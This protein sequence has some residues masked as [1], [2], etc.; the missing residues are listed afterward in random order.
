MSFFFRNIEHFQ[1]F[2]RPPCLGRSYHLRKGWQELQLNQ[3]DT[4][5]GGEPAGELL[6]GYLRPEEYILYSNSLT[7]T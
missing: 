2:T 1:V 5:M 7:S 3:E 4:Q 6:K